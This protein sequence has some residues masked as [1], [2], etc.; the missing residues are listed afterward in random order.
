[1]AKTEKSPEVKKAKTLVL[2][3]RLW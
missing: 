3:L 1:L 2:R